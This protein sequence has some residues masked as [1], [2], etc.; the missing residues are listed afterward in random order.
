MIKGRTHI[1]LILVIILI[2]WKASMVVQ[3]SLKE[4][5]LVSFTLEILLLLKRLAIKGSSCMIFKSTIDQTKHC[6]MQDWLN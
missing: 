6:Q 5:E 3:Y 1:I 2:S 4:E